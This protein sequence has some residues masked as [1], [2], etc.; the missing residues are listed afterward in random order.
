MG[1][2]KYRNSAAWR[3][4]KA[5]IPRDRCARCGRINVAIQVHHA[6]ARLADD[7]EGAIAGELVALCREC[8]EREHRVR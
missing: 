7:P 4:A 5:S 1:P 3:R 8:H 6:G 2:R